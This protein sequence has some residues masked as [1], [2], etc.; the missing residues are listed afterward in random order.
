LLCNALANISKV[1]L[2]QISIANY[3]GRLQNH[4]NEFLNVQ[5]EKR[6]MMEEMPVVDQ[7]VLNTT[8]AIVATKTG[9]R[10]RK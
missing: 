7:I 4:N 3:D 5:G 9:R 8:K 2:L 6:R 10:Y 1:D